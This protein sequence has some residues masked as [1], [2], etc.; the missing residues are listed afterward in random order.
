MKKIIYGLL[1]TITGIVLLFSYRTSLDAVS[2]TAST[3]GTGGATN[4]TGSTGSS[5]STGS[6]TTGSGSSSGSSS[7]GSSS[8]GSSASASPSASAS[9]SSNGLKDGTFTGASADTRYGPVQVAVTV[10]GGKITKV[11]VPVYP[12]ESFRDEEIN[13]QAVPELVSETLNA[14]SSNI[15]MVSGA[16]FTSEGYL[17]S[18]QSALDE[19]H[20]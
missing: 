8:T 18:L 4:G 19:A 5:N 13:R 9:A 1:A 20:A 7:S 16:T 17:K 2:P 10:S 14:Q 11:D 15:D 12:T 6:D 3:S